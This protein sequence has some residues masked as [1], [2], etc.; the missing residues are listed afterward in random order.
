MGPILVHE[1][2]TPEDLEAADQT[3]FH[4]SEVELGET[5]RAI[6]D[7]VERA[8]PTR[9]V[10]DSLGEM[11]LMAQG[12]L[13]FR[14]QVL[15]LKQA[16][17]RRGATPLLI[18]EQSPEAGDPQLRSLCHGVLKLEHRSRTCGGERQRL[19]VLK[20]RARAVRR[21]LPRLRHPARRHPGLP[22][23]DRRRDRAGVRAGRGPNR[24]PRPR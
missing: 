6:I 15:A 10:I 23:I 1:L 17:Q 11:R 19:R 3:V 4:P 9:V 16:F 2:A 21:R 7:A 5:A 8:R 24:H 20:L 13:R 22:P 14:R 18:D 12:A